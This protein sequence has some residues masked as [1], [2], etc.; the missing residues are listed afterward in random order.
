MAE[1]IL[2]VDSITMI[3]EERG[4]GIGTALMSA[5]ETWGRD[6]GASRARG[7]FLLEE[8]FLGPVL[9]ESLDRG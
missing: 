9:R 3:E 7:D 4:A 6:R 1:P 2:K 5:A 8:S